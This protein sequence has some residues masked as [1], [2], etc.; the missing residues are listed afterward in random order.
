[1][2]NNHTQKSSTQKKEKAIWLTHE[3]RREKQTIKVH[4][5]EQSSKIYHDRVSNA[6]KVFVMKKKN[7]ERKQECDGSSGPQSEEDGR[8]FNA[9]GALQPV[10]LTS[11]LLLPEEF[12]SWSTENWRPNLLHC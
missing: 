5:S 3:K 11:F 1:M 6:W 7:K 2:Q 12:D 10:A 4:C 9:L 8:C